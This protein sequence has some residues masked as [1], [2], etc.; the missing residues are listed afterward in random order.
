VG[1][2]E[3]VYQ[4]N[5]QFSEVFTG[6]WPQLVL[7]NES[8]YFERQGVV[9]RVRP[10]GTMIYMEEFQAI[11]EVD[12]NL[13]HVPFDRREFEVVFDVLGFGAE[14][15]LL[16]ANL[17]ESAVD[18]VGLNQWRIE[19]VRAEPDLGPPALASGAEGRVSRVRFL[20]PS[21]RSPW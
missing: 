5:Y 12:A 4:G 19:E 7:E 6:W 17:P 14:R 15:V 11:A 13:R 9:L 3:R 18:D 21:R 8:G 10:D 20:Y 1:S 2:D 16:T